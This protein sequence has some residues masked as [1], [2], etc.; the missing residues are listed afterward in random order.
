M[1]FVLNGCEVNGPSSWSII[2]RMRTMSSWGLRPS[3]SA[4]A[5]NAT[6]GPR[7]WTGLLA[8]PCRASSVRNAPR[9]S[10]GRS[11]N[12]LMRSL[13]VWIITESFVRLSFCNRSPL[14]IP[15]YCI[16]KGTHLGEGVVRGLDSLEVEDTLAGRLR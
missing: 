11:V 6:A 13:M 5:T 16:P 14:V 4:M 7:Y 8:S 15:W 12:Q 10:E 9:R 1:P 3:A 2:R